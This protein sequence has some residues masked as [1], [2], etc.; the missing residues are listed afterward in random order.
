MRHI[1]AL[2]PMSAQPGLPRDAFTTSRRVI[3]M[4]PSLPPSTPSG[5]LRVANAVLAY[6]GNPHK[7][8]LET[9]LRVWHSVNAQDP[10]ASL[11][12]VGI[13]EDQA[14]KYLEPLAVTIPRSVFFEGYVSPDRMTSLMKRCSVYLSAPRFED[15]GMAQLEALAC[16]MLLVTSV[17]FLGYDAGRLAKDL[18]ARLVV[19]DATVPELIKATMRAI[20]YS[21]KQR[22]AYQLSA[23]DLVAPYTEPVLLRKNIR[24]FKELLESLS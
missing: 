8:S 17:P 21:D 2:L 1:R 18:D 20:H 7:K 15:F 19:P 16:G 11:T 22:E 4:P 10:T 24:D 12:I 9:I 23:A 14:A 3:P 5:A 13:S 6:A